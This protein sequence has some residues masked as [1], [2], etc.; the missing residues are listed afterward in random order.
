VGAGAPGVVVIAWQG[1]TAV[2]FQALIV[3]FAFRLGRSTQPPPKKTMATR[4]D[5][6]MVAAAIADRINRQTREEGR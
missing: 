3:F 4:D 2:L 6:E 5:L 1:W